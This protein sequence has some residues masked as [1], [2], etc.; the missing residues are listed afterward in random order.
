MKFD[1]ENGGTK[2]LH[3]IR[4]FV[5]NRAGKL[6]FQHTYDT[7]QMKNVRFSQSI[8]FGGMTIDSLAIEFEDFSDTNL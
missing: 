6:K 4:E 7:I 8:L 5:G 1:Y 3:F 2:L